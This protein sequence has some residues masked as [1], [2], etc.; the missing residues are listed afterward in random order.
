MFDTKMKE[1]AGAVEVARE[2]IVR[3]SDGAGIEQPAGRTIQ[4]EEEV[5]A[6]EQAISLARQRRVVAIRKRRE[7]EARELRLSAREARGS[8]QG[9][10][11]TSISPA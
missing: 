4:M 5:R 10:A 11:E 8:P 2:E 1:A 6:I 7:I 3:L 9:K